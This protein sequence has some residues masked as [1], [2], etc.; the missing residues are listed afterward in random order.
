MKKNLNLAAVGSATDA[1]GNQSSC[2]FH[3]TVK[4]SACPQTAEYWRKNPALW[5][6]RSLVLGSTSYGADL[7]AAILKGDGK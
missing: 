3:V 1:A 7:L 6:V 4:P 5:P 2:S